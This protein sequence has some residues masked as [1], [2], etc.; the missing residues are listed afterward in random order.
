M[1]VFSFEAET[2]GIR[3]VR[4]GESLEFTF[5]PLEI[6]GCFGCRIRRC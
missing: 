1:G 4:D 6:C 5:D 3:E 2:E